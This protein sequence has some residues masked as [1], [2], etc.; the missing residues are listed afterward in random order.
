MGRDPPTHCT[1]CRS[2]AC[3]TEPQRLR[4]VHTYPDRYGA[5]G[6]CI[7][8][9]SHLRAAAHGHPVLVP[10]IQLHA[11]DYTIDSTPH[12]S[13]LLYCTACGCIHY[14]M[15]ALPS[16]DLR[17]IVPDLLSSSGMPVCDPGICTGASTISCTSVLY[18]HYPHLN[19]SPDCLTPSAANRVSLGRSSSRSDDVVAAAA[20]DDDGHSCRRS[21]VLSWSRRGW[22]GVAT[23]VD[24][25]TLALAVIS[26]YRHN[27]LLYIRRWPA[28]LA[29]AVGS[30]H[31]H[32]TE[33]LP[34]WCY[35]SITMS[36]WLRS[37]A[38]FLLPLRDESTGAW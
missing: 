19:T 6:G 3:R 29:S 7:C 36:P 27:R 38:P 24:P 37:L 22:H 30:F 4:G 9:I 12:L 8:M 28:G 21:L 2:A 16:T 13:L 1:Y 15:P 25:G 20:N 23:T 31:R 5:G 32:G 18:I 35:A 14:S 34:R 17:L 33:Q 11:T 10:G 26:A